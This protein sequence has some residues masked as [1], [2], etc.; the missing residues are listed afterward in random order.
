VVDWE[1]RISSVAG[2][3]TAVSMKEKDILYRLF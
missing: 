2:R 3:K 1:M